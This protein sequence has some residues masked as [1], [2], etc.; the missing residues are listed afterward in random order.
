[1][2]PLE[3]NKTRLL[4]HMHEVKGS[5]KLRGDSKLQLLLSVLEAMLKI[6]CFDDILS[7]V[8]KVSE[9]EA[10]LV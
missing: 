5:A 1:M 7:V 8:A 9:P 10:K 6:W 4:L 3:S 2:L